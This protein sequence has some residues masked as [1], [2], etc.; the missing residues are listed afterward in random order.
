[1]ARAPAAGRLER[2]ASPVSDRLV[3]TLFLAA[4]VHGILILGISFTVGSEPG[5]A[6]PSLDVRLVAEGSPE[7][8]RDRPASYLAQ[9]SRVGAGTT[10]A[11]AAARTPRGPP[12]QPTTA[13]DGPESEAET[14]TAG[15]R[16]EESVLA[17]VARRPTVRYSGAQRP[18]PTR[19]DAAR[20]KRASRASQPSPLRDT[21]GEDPVD[22]VQLTGPA[23][24]K[25][26]SADTRASVIA[27]YLDAWRRKVERLGTL[28]Y[29]T[30]ARSTRGAAAPVLE[31][32]LAADGSLRSSRIRRSSGNAALDDAALQILRLSAPFDPFPAELARE[33]PVLGFAYE[34]QFERG[35]AGASFGAP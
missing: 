20:A 35:A 4:L 26:V 2:P 29:P 19:E 31:I 3:T 14:E 9:V 13:E 30:I 7:E 22:R 16:T 24:G 32:Q 33:Y 21:G 23:Q 17:T 11:R 25:W 18:E 34:W 8:P 28:N 12:P 6:A 15:V 27:P 5:P 10:E 1:M